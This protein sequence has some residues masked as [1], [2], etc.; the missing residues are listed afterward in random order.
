MTLKRDIE[1][2]FEL[3]CLRHIDRSWKRFLGVD[4]QN[5]SEHIL[6]V[7]FISMIIAKQERADVDKAIK[8]AL[9]HDLSESR[10][11]DVDYLSR[12]FVKRDDE[13]AINEV[14]GDTTLIDLKRVWEDYEKRESIE[15][16]IVKDA[17]N[18]DVDIELIEQKGKGY[19][20]KAWDEIRDKIKRNYFTRTAKLIFDE[21]LKA[22][23]HDWHLNASNRFNAGDWKDV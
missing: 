9:V 2:I 14:L 16:K 3:G 22:N 21:V 12:Q 11:G 7:V 10:T 23:P 20:V 19:S 1:F 17:D 4:F 6:R 13:K 15:A 5:V 8:M 18:L